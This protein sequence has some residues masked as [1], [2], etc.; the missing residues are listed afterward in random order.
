MVTESAPAGIESR[1]L[2]QRVITGLGYAVV[3]L[4]AI[5]AGNE[6]LVLPVILAVIGWIALREFIS[7]TD[8]NMARTPR[9]LGLATVA[10][11]PLL[12]GISTLATP[13]NRVFGEAGVGPLAVPFFVLAVALGGYAWWGSM[14][15]DAGIRDV[16]LSFFGTA[17]IGLPLSFLVLIRHGLSGMPSHEGM[18]T[19]VALVLSVGFADMFAYFAGSLFGRHKIAPKISPKKSWEGLAGGVVGSVLVWAVLGV[20]ADPGFNLSVAA[21]FGVAIAL[22]GL[23]GDLFASRIKREAGVKDSGTILPGHGGMFDRI[24]SMLTAIPLAFI[25]ISTIGVVLDAFVS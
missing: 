19:A 14:T 16:A 25:F 2:L 18:L 4:G 13:A 17:Y 8:S 1:S 23:V 5:W 7:V 11:L 24:D 6:F 22:A 12:T 15:V 20:V 10:I 21:L 9:Q 3:G